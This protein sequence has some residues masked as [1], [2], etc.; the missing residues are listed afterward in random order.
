MYVYNFKMASSATKPTE[1]TQPINLIN[2]NLNLELQRRHTRNYPTIEI[3]NKVTI[4]KEQDKLDKEL[5]GEW[6][7]QCRRKKPDLGQTCFEVSGVP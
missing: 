6:N 1:A 4:Y 3:G 5:V 7:S 2:V